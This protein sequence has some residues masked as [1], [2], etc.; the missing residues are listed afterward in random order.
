MPRT[1]T[2][3]ALAALLAAAPSLRAADWPQWRGPRLNG[4]TTETG[5]PARWSQTESVAWV[6]PMPGPSAATPIV[7]RGRV[8]VTTPE[9]ATS[10]VV[11][12]CLDADSGK[13]LWRVALGRNRRVPGRNNMA[14]PSAVTD[15]ATVWFYTG[16]GDLVACDFAGPVR[17]RRQLQKDLGPF[18]LRYGYSSSPLLYEGRLY[19]PVLRGRE[20]G[21]AQGPLDSLLVAIDPATGKTLWKQVRDSDATQD[22]RHGYITPIPFEAHGRKE[23]VLPGAEYVTGHDAA[24]GEELWRWEFSPHDRRSRQRVVPSAVAGDGLI[25]VCRPKNRGL[26]ALKA[27]GEGR[28]GDEWVAWRF[29]QAAPDVATPLLLGGRIVVLQ[30]RRRAVAC[31]DAKTGKSLWQGPLKGRGAFFA[32]P[33]G[34]D[35]KIYLVTTSGD[36]TVLAEGDRFEELAHFPLDER[37]TRATIVAASRRLFVRTGQNLY[38]VA[39]P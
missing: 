24:T 32:S 27:G 10:Q 29:T 5:L 26:F 21:G 7:W 13:S 15:G 11:G 19:I 28:L 34:A 25:Y 35:G 8:F 37:E 39:K 12:L 9:P 18:A 30:D 2:A 1:R 22:S 16:A 3:M 6:T 31:L 20:G 23:I 36:V 14:S 38:C 4:S 33:T 17:W